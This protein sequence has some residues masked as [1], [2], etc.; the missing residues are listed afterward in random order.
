[1]PH[2][3]PALRRT[4]RNMKR[5]IFLFVVLGVK[6]DFSPVARLVVVVVVVIIIV[7]LV[8]GIVVVVAA[9]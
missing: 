7:M 3:R 4:L 8:L 9:P 6:I 2:Y 1:M 5:F